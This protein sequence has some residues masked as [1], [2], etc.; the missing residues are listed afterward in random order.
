MHEFTVNK[1]AEMLE[2][3]RASMARVLRSIPADAGTPK[4]PLYRLATAVRALIAY[5]VQP[6][7][8]RGNGDTARLAAEPF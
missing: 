1:I 7:G 5:E 4:K 3:D 2:R 6:D 8:R